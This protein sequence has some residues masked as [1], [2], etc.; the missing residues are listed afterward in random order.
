M[1]EPVATRAPMTI[2][3]AKFAKA[4]EETLDF[5]LFWSDRTPVARCLTTGW[6]R[7]PYVVVLQPV[8]TSGLV[9]IEGRPALKLGD[10]QAVCIPTGTHHQL[11]F[12]N[13]K[14][15]ALLWSHVQYRVFASLDVVSL[16]APPLILDGEAADAIGR[17]SVDLAA[18][19]D[20]DPLE[21]SSILA[22]KLLGFRL[23][24]VLVR[25]SD[26]RAG[27]L[28]ALRNAQRLSPVLSY[29]EEH[30]TTDR[31]D[32][33]RLSK[34]AHLSPSR[35]S[36]VFRTLVGTSPRQYVQK[37]RM[38]R[39]EQLLIGTSMKVVEICASAGYADAFHFSRL[40]KKLH[41]VSPIAYR[42]RARHVKT[43]S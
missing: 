34:L 37:R 41:G 23:L 36:A 6:R 18:I 1:L 16:L 32:L 4:V 5:E 24:D 29:I 13:T 21:L 25:A 11:S 10:R 20:M 28:E 14:E 19:R 15:G 17:I 40:F 38:T 9:E 27:A 42:E 22:K 26:P 3:P 7:M 39:A 12:E 43:A 2:D 31:L 35:L 30:L 8:G 33:D